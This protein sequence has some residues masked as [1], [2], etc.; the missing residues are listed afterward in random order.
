MEFRSIRNKLLTLTNRLLLLAVLGLSIASAVVAIV[1]GERAYR[2]NKASAEAGLVGKGILLV[3]NNS[4]ALRG[5]AEDNAFLSI[6]ELVVSTV[7]QDPDVVYGAYLDKDNRLWVRAGE[8]APGKEWPDEGSVLEDSA[9]AWAAGVDSAEYRRV[10][11]KGGLLEF[12]APVLS[13]GERLGTI[14]Y[15]ITTEGVDAAVAAL[16]SDSFRSSA[17]FVILCLVVG[18]A[19]YLIGTRAASK[20]AGRITQP[21]KELTDAADTIAA[22][23]YGA[24]VTT[25]T[26]DEVGILAKSFESM[27][28]TVKEYTDDLEQK[29]KDRTQRL[30]E[31]MAELKRSNAELEQFAYIASHDL[32]EP[33]RMVTS[34][35]GLIEKRYKDKLDDSGHEFIG[36]AVDGA[37]RMRRLIT[38]L[39]TYSRV[40]TKGK[41]L[42]PTDCEQVLETATKN[43][44]VSINE[45]NATV[46]HDPLP[47]VMADRGQLEQLFQNLIGNAL[48]F[49]KDRTPEVH[50]SVEQEGERWKV[51]VRDNGIGIAPKHRER[52]FQV[53]QRLHT[54]EEYQGTG[55]GLA[56]CKKIVERHG[57][58][59]SV[60]S[61]VGEG[62]TFLFSLQAANEQT[63]AQPE[64][65]EDVH[66]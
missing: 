31:A 19:A 21:L 43:L 4:L 48:K 7:S 17:L 52:I 25:R 53:F 22:G 58:E 6:R 35:L 38:D 42:E 32:Q 12:A 55:I 23:N 57:G 49:C 13:R 3:H 27:R 41:E 34:Y 5:M 47:T 2:K 33:L 28:K 37:V 9:S 62:T 30:D 51:G 59:I 10:A 20:E 1:M 15:G 45:H 65:K 16:R 44:E 29:V 46:T 24:A 8:A 66:A 50:V 64:R 63:V 36:F 14:R 54:R 26:D 11:G 61:E 60:E 39:L 56:V 40:G 18:F